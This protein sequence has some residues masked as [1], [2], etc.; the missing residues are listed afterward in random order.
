MKI[1][2]ER[3]D[4]EMTGKV[5][6]KVLVSLAGLGALCL[7]FVEVAVVYQVAVRTL[8]LASAYWTSATTEYALLYAVTLAAPWLVRTKT[9]VLIE[10]LVG[11]FTPGGQ[12][13]VEIFVCLLCIGMCLA[14]C[15]YFAAMGFE[16]WR[17]GEKDIR[18][19]TVPQ[20]VLYVPFP[21]MFLLSAIEFGRYLIGRD[22]L[23][24]GRGQDIEG[25]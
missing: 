15:Y 5:Y 10:S 9:H 12:R 3:L 19:I 6:P 23:I 22:R 2:S 7:V 17:W 1:C 18:S 21:M 11:T 8:D 14:L 13:A 20:W 25:I 24:S 4:P 16:A